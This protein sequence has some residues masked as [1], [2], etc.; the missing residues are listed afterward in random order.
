VLSPTPLAVLRGVPPRQIRPGTPR[1]TVH[2][3][4]RHT[5]KVRDT[6]VEGTMRRLEAEGAHSCSTKRRSAAL[7]FRGRSLIIGKGGINA[8]RLSP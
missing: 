5:R 6:P 7:V 1:R 2:Q 8:Q 4:A 3:S